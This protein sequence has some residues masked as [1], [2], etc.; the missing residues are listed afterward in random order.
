MQMQNVGGMLRSPTFMV[1]SEKQRGI[2]D[3][4]QK[5]EDHISAEY[6]KKN[7]PLCFNAQA[8]QK[9]HPAKAR[10]G[11]IDADATLASPML[12]GVCDGVSQVE[13]FGI[14][15][16]ELPVELLRACEELG[17]SQLIPGNTSPG[18][19]YG[20][21]ISL[22]EQA[23]GATEACGSTTVLLA[24]LDNMTK[25][26]GKLHPMAAIL[27]I[28]DC[29]LLILR[30]T[31]GPQGELEMIF[32]TEMQRIDGHVQEP[33]QLARFDDRVDFDIDFDEEIAASVIRDG[34]AV[35]CVSAY[36]G[37]ILVLGSDGVFDNLFQREVVDLCN[38]YMQPRQAHMPYQARSSSVLQ[39]LAHAIVQ[40][41]HAK[42]GQDG[43]QR[44]SSSPIGAGGKVDD[45]SCVVAE[46]VEWTEAH[47]AAWGRRR[48][49]GNGFACWSSCNAD[50]DDDVEEYQALRQEAVTR[51]AARSMR[52]QGVPHEGGHGDY[53]ASS[54][55]E[56]EDGRCAI[57]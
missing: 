56:S 20:G 16:S 11:S 54:S 28:G 22:L 27:S 51:G 17:C 21:P 57:T 36:E 44:S 50:H 39:Q 18:E 6:L 35:H 55:E 26:H 46:V 1:G 7:R 13:D 47:M 4:F 12:L 24:A 49:W 41:S 3:E 40:A 15:P 30:R 37:D 23:Y 42:P 9:T 48:R 32:N 29:E 53:E 2:L 31:Q 45:T 8:Y 10:L 25:I 38:E 33:L 43:K 34:S 19:S 14:D 52:M 5:R